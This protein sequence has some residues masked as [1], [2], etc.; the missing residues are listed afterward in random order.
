MSRQRKPRRRS[1]RAAQ[2]GSPDGGWDS[3]GMWSG[4]A[5][6]DPERVDADAARPVIFEG[7]E[8]VDRETYLKEQRPPHHGG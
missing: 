1:Q 7:E 2:S 5:Q 6:T 4:R 8:P 3:P